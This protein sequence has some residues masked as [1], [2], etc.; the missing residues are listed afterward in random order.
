[1]AEVHAAIELLVDHADHRSTLLRRAIN[2]LG[3]LHS[4]VEDFLG[5]ASLLLPGSA[6]A[7]LESDA[8][9]GPSQ[10][11]APRAH[12]PRPQLQLGPGDDPVQAGGIMLTQAALSAND[13]RTSAVQHALELLSMFEQDVAGLLSKF[14]DVNPVTARNVS[15]SNADSLL[16]PS[17]Q[18]KPGSDVNTVLREAAATSAAAARLKERATLSTQQSMKSRSLA[19]IKVCL[20]ILSLRF[21]GST[22]RP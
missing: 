10:D 18:I 2:L 4:G 9:L 20:C 21:S 17:G 5:V 13:S 22:A 12:G 3:G 16:L 14:P 7:A 1:M 8:E 11:E 15:I 19:H 6:D